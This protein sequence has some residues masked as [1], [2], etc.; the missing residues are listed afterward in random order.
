[1]RTSRT[2][3]SALLL[4][5][6]VEILRG[7]QLDYAVIGALAL[8]VHGVVRASTDADALLCVPVDRLKQ[9]EMPFRASGLH[10]VLHRGDLEDPVRGMLVLTD[11]YGNQVDLLGGLKGLDPQIFSRTLQVPFAGASLQVAGREDFI[12]MKCF[13]GGPQDLLDA[14][15]A[16]EGVQGPLNLD[17][18]RSLTRR[19]GR[20]AADRLESI[21]VA[22]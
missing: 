1:V 22:D 4:L 7:E 16:Y 20:D 6:I 17:L 15:S 8:A 19:F 11:K 3:Q 10:T 13:A 12:A 5:D 9:L 14:R 2:G 18:L 21:L